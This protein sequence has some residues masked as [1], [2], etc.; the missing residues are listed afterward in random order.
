[1]MYLYSVRDKG[2]GKLVNNITNPRHKFWEKRGS[3][4]EAISRFNPR[5]H[6]PRLGKAPNPADLE[7]VVFGLTEIKEPPK[8]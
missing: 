5:Y 1:M 8:D 2:T 6:N 4:E 7:I 3:A